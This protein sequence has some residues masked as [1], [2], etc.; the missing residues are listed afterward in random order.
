MLLRVLQSL[1][2]LLHLTNLGFYLSVLSK[3]FIGFTPDIEE[4]ANKKFQLIYSGAMSIEEAI[5]MLK[6][7][8]SSSNPREQK[9]CFC[10][11]IVLTTHHEFFID[12]PVHDSKPL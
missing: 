1:L 6:A 7:F 11:S 2:V 4:E 5:L 3:S 8:K 12:L 9:V 10:F